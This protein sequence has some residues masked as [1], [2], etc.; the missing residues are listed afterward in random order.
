MGWEVNAN[1]RPVNPRER[2]P[3]PI[4]QEAGWFPGPVWID[5]ENIASTRVDP[6]TFH[7]VASNCNDCA[8]P[9]QNIHEDHLTKTYRRAE[10]L[11]DALLIS[12]TDE[13]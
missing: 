13:G 3:L 11:L 10:I 9:S 6:R 1:L 12:T 4:V 2:D 7:H 5:V 8:I